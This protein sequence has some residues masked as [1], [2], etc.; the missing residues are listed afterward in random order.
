MITVTGIHVHR[1]ARG[2]LVEHWDELNLIGALRQ[3]RARAS[4][5]R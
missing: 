4:P 5:R 1:V 2:R 3:M